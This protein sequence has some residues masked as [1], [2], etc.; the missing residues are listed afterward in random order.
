VEPSW[1][2]FFISV[3]LFYWLVLL[4]VASREQSF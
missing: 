4:S 2:I 3:L 1:L